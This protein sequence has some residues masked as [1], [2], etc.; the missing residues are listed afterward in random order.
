MAKKNHYNHR[1]RKFIGLK[2]PGPGEYQ[3]PKYEGINPNGHYVSSKYPNLPNYN[4]GFGVEKREGEIEKI[5][6][7]NASK[8]PD[9]GMYSSGIVEG[10]SLTSAKRIMSGYRRHQSA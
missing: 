8:S 7:R 6:K 2:T 1:M 4:F 3:I 5:A 10:E 9:P